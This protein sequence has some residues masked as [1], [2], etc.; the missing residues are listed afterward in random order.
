MGLAIDDFGTDYSSLGYLKCLPITALKI[1]WG[2]VFDLVSD[3]DDRILSA[4][5]THSG[6]V[7]ACR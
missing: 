5:I 3:P 1:D 2:F 7:R 6:T 4:T